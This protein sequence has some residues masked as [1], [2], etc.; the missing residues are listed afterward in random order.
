M[1]NMENRGRVVRWPYTILVFLIV[2]FIFTLPMFPSNLS[3]G[4]FLGEV[5]LV[6]F[7]LALFSAYVL[8]PLNMWRLR[9]KPLNDQRITNLIKELSKKAG[10]KTPKLLILETPE[11]NAVTYQSIFGKRVVVTRGLMEAY[12]RGEISEK[13]LE[14][15]LAH[16]LGHH[17]NMDWL[18]IPLV[19]SFIS[20]FDAIAEILIIFGIM[21][22]GW[23]TVP[24]IDEE[25][26]GLYGL[27]GIVSIIIGGMLKIPALL[28][29]IIAF[30]HNRML[31]FA[32]DSFAARLT[33]PTTLASALQKVDRLN[34]DLVA[35]KVAAL[36]FPDRWMLK[37][38]NAS[39]L[40]RLF[41]SHPPLE[42]RINALVGG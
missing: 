41:D 7:S 38:K 21:S 17:K 20:L 19:F 13:E 29:S 28:A 36:P 3:F 24:W 1:E 39:P 2:S 40:D 11:V 16:E 14:S 35:R 5:F 4:A 26:R 6:G 8:T 32:A 15:I 22:I 37:P 10:M 9:L 27:A 23:A 25:Q 18:R 12:E 30:H 33:S 31:E 34:A 42:S